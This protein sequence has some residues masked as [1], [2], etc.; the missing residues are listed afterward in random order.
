MNEFGTSNSGRSVEFGATRLRDLPKVL[1]LREV[2]IPYP[3][4]LGLGLQL[5]H[6]KSV[7]N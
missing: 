6:S 7:I 5:S 3:P 1:I 2:R 4:K